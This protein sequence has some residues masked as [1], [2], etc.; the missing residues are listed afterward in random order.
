MDICAA[1]PAPY[2]GGHGGPEPERSAT[3]A[4]RLIGLQAA[5]AS[6]RIAAMQRELLAQEMGEIRALLDRMTEEV[7]ALDTCL[8]LACELVDRCRAALRGEPSERR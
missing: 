5:Q 3:A 8:A 6:E 7:R 4:L 2:T 1:S